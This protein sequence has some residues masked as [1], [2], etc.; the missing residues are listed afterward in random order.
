MKKLLILHLIVLSFGT[1]FGK[2]PDEVAKR[3]LE[4][5]IKVSGKYLYGE[6]VGN[7]KDE[8][9]KMAKSALLSEINKEAVTHPEWQ[10]AKTIQANGVEY[11]TDMIDLMRGNKFRV[12]A[13][14]KK[15]N[16]AVIFGNK[17]PEIKLTD[18]K[19]Q[20]GKELPATQPQKT[21]SEVVQII[22]IPAFVEEKVQ[23][24][25]EEIKVPVL[26]NSQNMPVSDN[27]MNTG[28][29]LE[30]IVAAISFSEIQKIL[31]ANKRKGKVVSGTIDKL[32]A[33]E[34]VYLIVYRKTGDIVAILDKG[35]NASRKDLRSG[36]IKGKEILEQNQVIWFQLF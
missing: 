22:P 18:K 12:I 6:A 34:K 8:A 25:K 13:Y 11:N 14:I 19:V 35:S 15:D 33:P 21:Q 7:T 16:I 5:E 10:F 23:P 24:K 9:I 26:E 31:D 28:D 17:A 32:T 30:Q 29:I 36:E 3:T 20:H 27:H 1:L 4:R 2:Q